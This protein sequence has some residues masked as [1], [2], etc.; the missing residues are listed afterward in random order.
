[1]LYVDR[2]EIHFFMDTNMDKY[3]CPT[4]FYLQNLERNV[5]NTKTKN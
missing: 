5:P 2:R 1:M 4:R 3:M